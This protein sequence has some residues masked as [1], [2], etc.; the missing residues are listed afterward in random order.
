[1][2]GVVCLPCMAAYRCLNIVPWSGKL[3]T[4][5]HLYLCLWNDSSNGNIVLAYYTRSLIIS[6]FLDISAVSSLFWKHLFEAIKGVV[7]GKLA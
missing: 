5:E 4:C 6:F 2:F 7:G 1:M 3:V